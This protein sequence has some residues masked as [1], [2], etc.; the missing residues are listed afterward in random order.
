M[1]LLRYTQSA[2]NALKLAEQK[3]REDGSAV[4]GSEHIL[5]GI[6]KEGSGF[7]AALLA[8][9]EIKPEDIDAITDKEGNKGSFSGFSP[10]SKLA[11][12]IAA[13][14]TV[15]MGNG[16]IG[17]E[18]I[19]LGI[20]LEG[21]GV[22]ASF[23][24]E[25]C[26]ITPEELFRLIV[27]AKGNAASEGGSGECPHAAKGNAAADPNSK[28]PT[29]DKFG[30]DLTAMA[31][32]AK[33]DPVIGREKEV[34]RVIQILS[35]RTKNNPVLIG[36]PG[37]GKTAIAEGLA[38]MIVKG[39]VPST[40]RDKRVMM[41]DVSSMVAGTK[42]RG[43]FEERMQNL[44][45][46]VRNAD[47]VLLFID[48]VHTL[49]G[50]GSAEG[51][52][53]ASNILKPALARGELQCIGATTLDEYRKHIEK[54]AALERRFQTVLVGEPTP[55]DAIAILTGLRD[56]YEAHH[57]VKITD[58]AI[59]AAVKLSD[60]YISDRYLP[61]K[62]IDLIDEASSM[63]QL[64][65]KV[66]PLDLQEMEEELA[67]LKTE[68]EAAIAAQDFEKAAELRDAEKAQLHKIEQAK[69][70]WEREQ[71]AQ[72]ITVDEEEIAKILSDWTGVPVTRLCSDEAEQL[73]HLEEKLH[74]R[75]I[76]QDEAI[77]GVS[78]AIRRARAGLKDV[79]RPVGSFIFAGPTGVGK[80]EL[81]KA[82]A[83]SLFGSDENMIRLDMSEY[84]EKHNASRL[85]G[86]P[87]GYVGYEEGGQ[88]TEAVR[89]NP[90]SVILL[91]EIEKA[92]PAVFDMLLQVLDDGRL[93]DNTGRTVDFRNTVIIMTSNLG[94]TEGK[95]KA[96][97]G[98]GVS[99]EKQEGE[100]NEMKSRVE[101]ALK[102]AF[103][104]EF[105]NR[106]DDTFVFHSLTGE[107][108]KEI[109]G[110]MVRDLQKR[111]AEREITLAVSDE[112]Y[113]KIAE[114]GF[115]ELYGARPLR[116]AIQRHLEDT[117]SEQM[118]EGKIADGDHIEAVLIDGEIAF[119]KQGE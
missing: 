68:K 76:G 59:E 44:V 102:K 83:A 55:E 88:L 73:L 93:T 115:D 105:L 41:I 54:D 103:R 16:F 87:P 46:E 85:V 63:V 71:Q 10:R 113:Q 82:L 86:A 70:D 49:V 69:A 8:Q 117:L 19:L 116:R 38:Q 31:R 28:T 108:I 75:V 13:E 94:L 81:A 61:D 26:G 20:L 48:E 56:K 24:K 27:E 111:L 95:K 80:T 34:Q 74:E 40:L 30:R 12:Q 90:Y 18:H 101:E 11:L 22:A 21:G 6:A 72:I 36:E 112:V 15:R 58:K 2:Q 114:V 92:H 66:A 110:I 62:A 104:P 23:L 4:I 51:S 45:E 78:K 119:K 17:T 65:A 50:A 47:D 7:A 100:H 84:M 37:V 57:R 109:A 53:D 43:D 39:E 67:S 33:L 52:V 32:E 29:L 91:D 9:R 96:V 98:F 97:L 35:R 107:Q 64:S 25:N 79:K 1:Q 14:Q 3:A 99:E 60:R 106:I 118:L 42:Y 89:R 77:K 5:W